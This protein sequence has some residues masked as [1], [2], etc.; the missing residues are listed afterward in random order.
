MTREHFKPELWDSHEEQPGGEVPP[1]IFCVTCGAE[2]LTARE[3]RQHEAAEH[4]C[5]D[6]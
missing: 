3:L 2:F 4:S 5:D 6:P 1:N